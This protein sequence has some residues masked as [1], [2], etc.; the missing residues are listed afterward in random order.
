MNLSFFNTNKLFYCKNCCHFCQLSIDW[1]EHDRGGT[2][3]VGNGAIS[4]IECGFSI[5]FSGFK[6]LLCEDMSYEYDEV[7]VET[8]T[9][10]K[11]NEEI[12]NPEGYFLPQDFSNLHD[13]VLKMYQAIHVRLCSEKDKAF[14]DTLWL[15]W[16]E[17]MGFNYSLNTPTFEIDGEEITPVAALTNVNIELIGEHALEHENGL[18]SNSFYVIVDDYD[19]NVSREF[20][21]KYP[22]FTQVLWVDKLPCNEYKFTDLDFDN[23]SFPHAFAVHSPFFKNTIM[24]FVR[25]W[26]CDYKTGTGEAF[27]SDCEQIQ[28]IQDSLG[29]YGKCH[30]IRGCSE[31]ITV[32]EGAYTKIKAIHQREIE[33]FERQTEEWTNSE[34]KSADELIDLTDFPK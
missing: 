15:L 22:E 20:G 16:F 34:E 29:S 26:T 21:R 33:Y 27:I 8:F 9:L 23:S 13:S 25:P 3:A 31:A 19:Y 24:H 11:T 7:S 1:Q 2:W 12:T 5:E 10:A 32:L 18:A 4:C 30:V 6:D 17:K 28:Y 14:L